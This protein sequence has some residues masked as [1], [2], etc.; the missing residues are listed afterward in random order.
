M[1]VCIYIYI[2]N[3]IRVELPIASSAAIFGIQMRWSR[4][5]PPTC[6]RLMRL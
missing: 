4:M 5:C 3:N 2:L 1:Y 6:G